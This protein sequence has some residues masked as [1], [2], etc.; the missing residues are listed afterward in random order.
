M[1]CGVCVNLGGMCVNLGTIVPVVK[2]VLYKEKE[3]AG[4]LG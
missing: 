1:L 3:G 4:S 2:A